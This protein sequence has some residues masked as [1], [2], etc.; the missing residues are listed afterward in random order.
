MLL[1]L[2]NISL[3]LHGSCLANKKRCR[4]PNS[5]P[6]LFLFTRPCAVVCACISLPLSDSQHHHFP[7]SPSPTTMPSMGAQAA[8]E[9]LIGAHRRDRRSLLH[10]LPL[11]P[12]LHSW[13][14]SVDQFLGHN[15]IQRKTITLRGILIKKPSWRRPQMFLLVLPSALGLALACPLTAL[16]APPPLTVAHSQGSF[17]APACCSH[18][19][20][21]AIQ[22]IRARKPAEKCGKCGRR[23]PLYRCQLV[24]P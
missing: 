9:G 12:F 2:S 4:C 5:V 3:F 13:P 18:G 7:L 6:S 16:R 19:W 24:F 15:T 1:N 8:G 17:Q 10:F 11:P 21:K 14:K 23:S 20:H 22:P